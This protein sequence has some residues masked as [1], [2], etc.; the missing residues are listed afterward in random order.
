MIITPLTLGN[1]SFDKGFEGPNG[2]GEGLGDLGSKQKAVVREFPGGIV[3]AQ[4]YGSFPKQITWS[5]KLIGG[6]AMDRSFELQKL[7]DDGEFID[8]SWGEFSFTGFVEDYKAVA[9]AFNVIEYSIIFRPLENTATVASTNTPAL[10][11]PVPAPTITA[12]QNTAAQQAAAPA[13]GATLPPAVQ[14]GTTTLNNSVNQA[15]QGAG[16]NPA[17][18]P[19]STLQ[20]LTGQISTI[21]TALAPL[22]NGSDP[23]IASAAA[24]LNGTL[25][26]LASAFSSPSAPIQ[27]TIFR[28]NP[29]VYQLAAQYLGSPLLYG[30]ILDA[31]PIFAN[32]PLPVTDGPV[33]IIVPAKSNRITPSPSTVMTDALSAA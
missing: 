32:D 22:I 12:A 17:Q 30:E 15:L 16:G 14:S 7:C 1:I 10:A 3:T 20:S 6:N 8:F 31:N 29:N 13:S 19:T 5:G 25:S 33:S 4:L 26:I 23:Q 9:K 21:Q 24:D 18:I 2:D 28:S 11:G 27:T